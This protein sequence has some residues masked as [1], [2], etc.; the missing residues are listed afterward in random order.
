MKND[1]NLLIMLPHYLHLLQPLNVRVFSAFKRA[2]LN[3]TDATSRLSTQRIS[4]PEWLEMFIRARAK[5][6][7]PD[8]IVSG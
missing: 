8:N 2:H 4:R 5:A 6:V 3:K 1:I 7:K